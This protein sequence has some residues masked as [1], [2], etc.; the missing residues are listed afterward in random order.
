M[1]IKQLVDWQE[2]SFLELYYYFL[3]KS[4]KQNWNRPS[5]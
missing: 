5:N 2:M 1:T 4:V 3:L